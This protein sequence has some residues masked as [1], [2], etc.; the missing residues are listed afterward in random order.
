MRHPSQTDL[1]LLAGEDLGLLARWRLARHLGVCPD[2]QRLV[3]AFRR[4]RLALLDSAA[5]LPPDLHWGHLA[6]EMRANIHLG[7]SAGECVA[8]SAP[9]AVASFWRPAVVLSSAVLMVVMGWWLNLPQPRTP[10]VARAEGVVVEATS[11]GIEIKQNDRAMTLLNSR[12]D[13][14][15]LSVNTQGVLRARYVDPDTGHVTIN[16]VYAQ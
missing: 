16:N 1:A 9:P 6:A 11:S 14:V 3:E 7:L 15:T 2:C 10:S 12:A 4:D 13:D 8:T 5:D